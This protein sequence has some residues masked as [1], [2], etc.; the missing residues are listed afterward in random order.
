MVDFII[1]IK[2]FES[3]IHY[4]KESAVVKLAVRAESEKGTIYNEKTDCRF[5]Y[6]AGYRQQVVEI[7]WNIN[8]DVMH[9]LGLHSRYTTNFQEFELENKALVI[10]ANEITIYVTEE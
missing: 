4:S 7:D 9:A 6:D 3:M 8:D 5:F 10:R 2:K 1:T